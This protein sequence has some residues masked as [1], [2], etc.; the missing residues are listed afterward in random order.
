MVQEALV[1]DAMKD[2]AGTKTAGVSVT[3]TR[4]ELLGRTLDSRDGTGE[5]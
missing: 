4:K 3:S 1:Q 2:R 5:K